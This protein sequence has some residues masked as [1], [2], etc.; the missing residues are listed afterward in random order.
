MSIRARRRIQSFILNTILSAVT[1]VYLV[2][3]LYLVS[4]ALKEP[5]ESF[6]NPGLIPNRVDFTKFPEVWRQVDVPLLAG[7][8][9]IITA[10]TVLLV[11]FLGALAGYA[12][13]R[14]EFLGRNVFL[15]IFL[16]GLMVP[17]AG[18]IV[19]LYHLNLALG[20][21]DTYLGVVGPYVAGGLP[22]A[23]LFLRSYFDTLPKAIEDSA[24]I[25][26][27]S[28]FMIFWRI[29]LPLTKPALATVAMFNALSAWNEFLLALLFLTRERL[30]TLPLG[31]LVFQRMYFN[32]FE[33]MFALLLMVAIPPVV[34]FLLMQRQYI[35]GLTSGAV[36]G[37]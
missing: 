17:F 8:S 21:K 3:M 10:S 15:L 1:L 36:K 22:F 14:L 32:A 9:L 37:G 30:R 26:G 33:H 27:A 11:I 23:V 6:T 13:S 28:R 2:P 12:F 20:T 35:A 34:L 19:P 4:T 31:S 24:L 16:A 25:D 29:L 7:N 5:G 18:V